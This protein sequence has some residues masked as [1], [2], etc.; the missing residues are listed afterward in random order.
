MNDRPSFQSQNE[1]KKTLDQES[2]YHLQ[3]L[4]IMLNHAEVWQLNL[5]VLGVMHR[6]VARIGRVRAFCSQTYPVSS[7]SWEQQCL[8]SSQMIPTIRESPSFLA[9]SKAT[10]DQ[11]W[12]LSR[13]INTKHGILNRVF[14]RAFARFAFN[15]FQSRG[16]L[17]KIR[18]STTNWW[19]KVVRTPQWCWLVY[20]PINYR[21]NLHKA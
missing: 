15:T 21:Y 6:V 8:S 19:H 4:W 5:G 20:N 13:Q 2:L 14:C 3:K 11:T 9:F 10:F 12:F 16:K 7:P 17:W 1:S 18:M